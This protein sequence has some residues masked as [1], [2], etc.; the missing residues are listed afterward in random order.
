VR[1]DVPKE[2]DAVI[3]KALAK[4]PQQ[5]YRTATEFIAALKPF[6][7]E[8]GPIHL[9][10]PKKHGTWMLG[11]AAFLV[12]AAT[13]VTVVYFTSSD[14]SAI[15]AAIAEVTDNPE[16]AQAHLNLGQLLVA[17]GRHEEADNSL[18]HALQLKRSVEALVLRAET[19]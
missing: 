15:D 5:R 18:T 13:G 2:L 9:P 1:P 11:A 19:R 14:T 16:S 8:P 12:A 17:A 3:R 4:M 6:A 7:A 10:L